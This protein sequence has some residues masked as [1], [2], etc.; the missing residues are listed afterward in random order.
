MA[1]IFKM[2][3]KLVF[4]PQLGEFWFFL[5]FKFGPTYFIEEKFFVR[6]KVASVVQNGGQNLKFHNF[7]IF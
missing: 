2:A 7:G 5:C 4:R 1:A 6:F 3:E